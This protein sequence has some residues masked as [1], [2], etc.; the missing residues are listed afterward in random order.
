[1]S[2]ASLRI[3]QHDGNW[4]SVHYLALGGTG[5][6]ALDA[7]LTYFPN[8]QR[9]VLCLDNDEAGRTRTQEITKH[10]AGSGKTVQDRAP[11]LGKDYNDIIV[12]QPSWKKQRLTKLWRRKR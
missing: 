9:V 8:I 12:R 7:Y 11:P 3:L 6:A 4:H 1:M 2:G 5:Y 10:L